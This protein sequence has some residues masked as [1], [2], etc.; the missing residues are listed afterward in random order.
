VA[1][2]LYHLSQTGYVRPVENGWKLFDFEELAFVANDLPRLANAV[3]TLNPRPTGPLNGLIQLGKKLL[4]RSLTW[5]TRPL[6]K[7]H[8]SVSWSIQEIVS[9]LDRISMNTVG[10]DQFSRNV[11]TL[12]HISMNAVALE[13]RLAQLETRSADLAESLQRQMELLHEQLSALGSLPGGASLQAPSWSAATDGCSRADNSKLR[14]DANMGNLRT[15]YIIGLFGTGRRYIN[16]LM[17]Q[18]IGERAQYFRDT[19]R[20]HQGPTPMIYSGHVT[21]KYPCRAQELPVVM[22]LILDSVRSRFADSI[23]IYRHPLDSLL[24]NWVW[25][26]TYIRENKAVSGISQAYANADELCDDLEREFSEFKAFAEGDP[27]FFAAAP[28]PRFLSFPEF[29]E[30]TELHLDAATLA[31]RLEDFM[32]DARREFS[33]IAAV[34]SVELDLSRS[35]IAPPRTKPYGYLAV[36]EKVPQF[37]DFVNRLDAETRNRI[38]RIG[39]CITG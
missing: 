8:V 26:H 32:T 30:E 35:S 36:Q 5:Y 23:F 17:L 31:L 25:W 3:G 16:E 29:V 14:L 24:T 20:L 21:V 33:K 37:R 28:G 27:R 6:R 13:K 2:I 10:T 38:E 12:E 34:M 11:D 9:A 15:A 39:Y 22:R 18:H 7:Y 1:A 4:A 19:I